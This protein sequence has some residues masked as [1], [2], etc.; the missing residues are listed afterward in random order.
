MPKE[1]SS[2]VLLGSR[3]D[4]KITICPPGPESPELRFQPF[5][6][7]EKLGKTAARSL[8]P[9]AMR[10]ISRDPTIGTEIH[11][12]LEVAKRKLDEEVRE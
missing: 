6:F 3:T 2:D 7:D 8:T 9:E 4:V 1:L 10:L 5:Q 12:M 11:T